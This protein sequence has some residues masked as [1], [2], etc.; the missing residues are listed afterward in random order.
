M[1]EGTVS[2]A[3]CRERP[4]SDLGMAGSKRSK[5]AGRLEEVILHL[6]H[7]K[8][9]AS[10]FHPVR[11]LGCYRVDAN[12]DLNRLSKGSDKHVWCS[13]A[14][15]ESWKSQYQEKEGAASKSKSLC[16]TISER[17]QVDLVSHT[18]SE[19]R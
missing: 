4:L 2:V 13:R 7:T 16:D 5:R 6:S 17:R 15:D 8:Y 9:P 3:C 12:A 1:F 19:E 18:T 11:N 10:A 14:F